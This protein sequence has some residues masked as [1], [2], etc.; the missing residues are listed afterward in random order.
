MPRFERALTAHK[1][2]DFLQTEELDNSDKDMRDRRAS[3][4]PFERVA[5]L[6]SRNAKKEGSKARINFVR[7]GLR[8]R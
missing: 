3:R 7:S 2:T 4:H 1:F 8:R 6:I 5:T